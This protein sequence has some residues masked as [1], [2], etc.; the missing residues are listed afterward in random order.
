MEYHLLLVLLFPLLGALLNTFFGTLI[1]RF[2]PAIATLALFLSFVFSLILIKDVASVGAFTHTFT[3]W[4]DAGPLFAPFA[5]R[6][7]ELSSF[8]ALVVTLISFLVH[9]YSI[10]YMKDHEGNPDPGIRRYFI[11]LNLFVFSMLLLVLAENFL[12]LFIGWEGVGLCSY[13]LIGYEHHREAARD[14]GL[15]AFVV[16]RIGDVSFI[17]GIFLIF[18]YFD[19]LDFTTL[20]TKLSSLDPSSPVFEL[21][22]PLNI[23]DLIALLLF[24]GAIGKSAQLPLYVWLPDA[25][26]GPTPVSALIHAATMVTA[27]VYLVARTFFSF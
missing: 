1:R 24:G 2:V 11:Y 8:M 6:A 21:F 16:N 17:I 26:E 25:M 14:A 7:D 20:E 5:L 9:L 18:I 3:R 15:K 12:L 19:A 13:L 4:I 10:G 27:G 23:L 22:G